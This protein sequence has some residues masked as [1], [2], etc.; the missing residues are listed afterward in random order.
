[1]PYMMVNKGDGTL[2]AGSMSDLIEHLNLEWSDLSLNMFKK[3]NHLVTI[4]SVDEHILF[5]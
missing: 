1:M 2:Y 4:G 3:I 5:D